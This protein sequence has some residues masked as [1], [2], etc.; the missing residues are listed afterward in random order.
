M[1]T[2]ATT[3]LE[4]LNRANE[5]RVVRSLLTFSLIINI[6]FVFVR[7]NF[8]SVE[9]WENGE[10]AQHLIQGMGFTFSYFG[11]PL[12]PT[13]IMAPFYPYFL[14]LVYSLFG[15]SPAAHLS[16]QIFQ[17]VVQAAT[18][19]VV[20]YI[21]KRLFSQPVA[22]VSAL[23][24]AAFPD[25]LYGTTVIH[26]ITIT[27]FGI[28]LLILS[29]LRLRSN[30]SVKRAAIS[31]AILGATALVFPAVLF[32]SPFVAIW[33]LV[34]TTRKDDWTFGIKVTASIAL[35]AFI[36]VLPWTVRNYL[37]HDQ[38]VLIK[39]TGYN[40]W[41]GNTPPAV[42]NGTARGLSSLDP[43]T[44]AALARLTEA[45][46]NALLQGIA[47][48]YVVHHPIIFVEGI[49]QKMIHF[50]WFPPAGQ[51]GQTG[52][53]RKVAYAPIF[54]TGLGGIVLSRS[55]RRELIPIYLL[56]V[57]FTFSYGLFFVRPRY[58]VPTTQP[59][60]IVFSSYLL[61]HAV[62]DLLPSRTRGA[63]SAD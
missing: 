10:I 17:A 9:T 58:R 55:K 61:Y 42:Y 59:Y 49:V 12:Q 34:E 62:T 3:Y 26:Q 2:E 41:R 21:A 52:L 25:Y 29:L 37:V 23:M 20:F 36:I 56:F 50:W 44:R 32:Y 60:L 11:N 22:I 54:L 48:N 27:T 19:V 39:A 6:L 57:A 35:I 1:H 7:R 40:F 13:S 46:G 33:I 53:L 30:P 18:V 31:G 4:K 47:V 15:I 51:Q 63:N 14:A 28:A 16:I 45:E 43:S 24:L 38:F 5:D 8:Y